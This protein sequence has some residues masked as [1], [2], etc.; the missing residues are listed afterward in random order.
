MIDRK[1]QLC[2]ELI[3][4]CQQ[5][6][7]SVIP[8]IYWDLQDLQQNLSSETLEFYLQLFLLHDFEDID[9][10]TS[11]FSHVIFINFANHRSFDD[12]ID[13]LLHELVHYR[14]PLKNH[15]QRFD[16]KIR[17][18][19]EGKIWPYFDRDRFIKEFASKNNKNYYQDR[20]TCI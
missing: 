3:G 5:L 1:K 7:V 11:R 8:K 17:D 15:S 14:F 16:K 12:L 4:Y 18:L 20:K 19:K 9:G 10:A 13:T 2:N 6:G